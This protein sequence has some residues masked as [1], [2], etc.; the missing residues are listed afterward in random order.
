MGEVYVNHGVTTVVALENVPKAQRT[1]S[2]TALDLPRVFHS[3][4][5]PLF[6]EASS[7]EE[8]RQAMR[9][10]LELEPD[11]ANFATHNERNARA[12]AV[13]AAEAHK[14]G[15]MVFG[16]AENAPAALR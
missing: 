15:L 6:N 13:A 3:A 7:D 11:V 14:A 4:D 12:F 10:W 5:R 2:P 9:A 1:R 16:H 8:V